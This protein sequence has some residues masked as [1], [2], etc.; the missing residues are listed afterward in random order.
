METE[1]VHPA[2]TYSRGAGGDRGVVLGAVSVVVTAAVVATQVLAHRL[3]L[4]PA[5][6]APLVGAAPGSLVRLVLAVAAIG[7]LAVAVR[8]RARFGVVLVPVAAALVAGVF[9]PVYPPHRGMLWTLI[10]LGSAPH[11]GT[12]ALAWGVAGV[13]GVGLVA[14]GLRR[15]A[16]RVAEA[17]HGSARFAERRDLVRAGMLRGSGGIVLGRWEGP[18]GRG[19]LRDDSDQHVLI[20]IPPGG[21]KTTGPVL[22]TLLGETESSAFVVDPKAELW[23]LSAGWRRAQGHRCLRFGPS[24]GEGL[25][26]NVFDEIE[27]GTGEVRVVSILAENLV[28][29]PRGPAAEDHWIASARKLFRGLAL[30]VLYAHPEPSMAAVLDVL[31][32]PRGDSGLDGLFAGM[33]ATEHDPGLGRGWRDSRTGEPTPTH[34]EVARLAR[35]MLD[36]PPRE[37]GSIVSTLSAFLSLWGDEVIAA[38]TSRSGFRLGELA[39]RERPVTLYVTLPYQDLERLGPLVRM[40]LALLTL[41]VTETRGAAGGVPPARRLLLVLDEFR[42]LGRVLILEQMLA[43]LRGYGVRAIVVVQDLAQ[44]RQAY[45]DRESITGN[46]QLQIYAATQNLDT[47]LHASRLTGESTVRYRRKSVAPQG[48]ARRTTTSDADARRPLLTEGEIGELPA[49]R[50]L[51][52]K[53]GVPPVLAFKLPYYEHPELARRARYPAP[54]APPLPREDDR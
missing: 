7:G 43:Y 50:L 18:G 34:P 30:H 46:C 13:V 29:Y 40:M 53:A 23:T 48:L 16:V 38:S 28:A 54:A 11:E 25:P 32:D 20:T 24:T 6:G 26:W 49:D 47:R 17:V 22:G 21:G 36:T 45:S 15:P 44:L 33:L 14:V 4:D 51:I 52:S 1:S 37:R 2:E 42:A 9:G 41:Q 3:G 5:L 35:A 39:R 19:L 31:H 12:L 8:R 10:L 27:R